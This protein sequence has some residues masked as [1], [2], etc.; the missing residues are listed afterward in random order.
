MNV[1]VLGVGSMG[2]NHAR[3]FSELANLVCVCDGRQEQAEKIAKKFNTKWYIDYHDVLKDRSVEAVSIAT[4]TSTHF[5][6]AVDALNAGKHVLIEKPICSTEDEAAELIRT[7][8]ATGMT[9]AV[10]LIERHNPAV[11]VTKEL[12]KKNEFGDVVTMASRRV[13]MN[14]ARIQDSG[15]IMDM[16]TH[17]I[18]IMRYFAES[19]V[20][21]VYSVHSLK[22]RE[23]FAAI[24]LT[25]ENGIY[26]SIEV[27]WLTPM[28]VRKASLTCSRKFVEI[29]Y[30]NQTIQVSSSQFMDHT[31]DNLFQVPQEYDVRLVTLRKEEPLKNELTDFINAVRTGKPPLVTGTEALE[32]LKVVNAAI[33]S[34]KTKMPVTIK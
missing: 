33:E 32:T 19:P 26:A 18:D 5:R 10:G 12:I 15:V 9:L 20:E 3:V 21:T 14:P 16:G 34:G 24:L 7:A 2:Q 13:S 23:D 28:K 11:R 1:A 27:N 29:D 6:I 17:D 4:P 25:F 30:M 22:E 8:E 31:P